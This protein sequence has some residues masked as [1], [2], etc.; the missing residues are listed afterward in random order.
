[1]LLLF[2]N[3]LSVISYLLVKR[4]CQKIEAMS[5][6]APAATVAFPVVLPSGDKGGFNP[7]ASSWVLIGRFILLAVLVI[8]RFDKEEQGNGCQPQLPTIASGLA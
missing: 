1:L 4:N 7:H 6:G 2:G 3:V 5:Y 8:D